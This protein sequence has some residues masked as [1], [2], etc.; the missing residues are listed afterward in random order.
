MLFRLNVLV[1][2][3]SLMTSAQV[4]PQTADSLG[5][6]K[7]ES[8]LPNLQIHIDGEPVTYAKIPFFSLTPGKYEITILHP[9]RY[10]WGNYDWRENI[11]IASNDT[12]TLNPVFRYALN[13]RT[14]PFGARVFIDDEPKGKT[15]LTVFLEMG[16]S[17]EILIKKQGYYDYTI[18]SHLIKENYLRI[19]LLKKDNADS[20]Q[21]SSFDITRSK[22]ARYR[23]YAYGFWVA[24]LVSGFTTVYLK[25][26]AEDWYDRYLTA[27][28][29]SRMN[30]YYQKSLDYDKYTL[31]SLGAL[32]GCF[33][34]SFYFLIKSL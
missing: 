29:M 13:I 22:K 21:M 12:L 5:Y 14:T 17:Y 15:P 11:N 18:Q 8:D 19:N 4:L 9:N 23:K 24:S 34:L 31:I 1:I 32:Q 20:E 2:L 28:S 6:L 26:E 33:G 16:S 3:F 10:F 30:D 27:G 25:N 7:I